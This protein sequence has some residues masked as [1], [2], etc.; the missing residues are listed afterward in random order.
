MISKNYYVYLWH[1]CYVQWL[2]YFLQNVTL[3]KIVFC[4]LYIETTF[5]YIY[6]IILKSSYYIL[7]ICLLYTVICLYFIMYLQVWVSFIKNDIL[8][9]CS[10]PFNS[11]YNSYVFCSTFLVGYDYFRYWRS[12]EVIMPDASGK[13]VVLSSLEEKGL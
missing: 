4:Y 9:I 11:F 5:S 2:L 12:Y 1:L 7:Q 3:F 10:C 8:R 6:C 13:E